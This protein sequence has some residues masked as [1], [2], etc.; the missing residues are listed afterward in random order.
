M[1]TV[2]TSM[3]G[4]CTRPGTPLITLLP[5]LPP[6]ICTY[7]RTESTRKHADQ[8]FAWL[9]LAVSAREGVSLLS[10]EHRGAHPVPF[11]DWSPH[12]MQPGGHGGCCQV[13]NPLWADR[14]TELT[15][16][17]CI[18]YL[19]KSEPSFLLYRPNK[20]HPTANLPRISLTPLPSDWGSH[21]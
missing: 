20:G 5:G 19:F 17:K 12:T 14:R 4:F 8:L 13:K 11:L 16:N 10:A 1:W 21:L 9:G 18:E 6:A 2:W 7:S 15:H 3:R